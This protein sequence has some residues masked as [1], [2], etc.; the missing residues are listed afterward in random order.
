MNLAND[1]T[2]FWR[3]FVSHRK[4][5]LKL[6]LMLVCFI[7]FGTNS[8]AQTGNISGVVYD[9]D[10][11][12]LENATV[13]VKQTKASTIT[14]KEG[15]YSIKASKDQSLVITHV[16]FKP[17][18]VVVSSEGVTDIIMETKSTILNDIVVVGYGTQKR[19]ILQ[20]QWVL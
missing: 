6:A 13:S 16:N 17:Q 8:F 3:Y 10:N 4:L 15:K 20:V 2:L 1:T 7:T 5:Y 18:T 14:D 9:A 11:K 12:P 19:R